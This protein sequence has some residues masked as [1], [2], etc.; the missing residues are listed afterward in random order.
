MCCDR[1]L[2]W[3]GGGGVLP[4]A[5]CAALVEKHAAVGFTKHQWV[6]RGTQRSQLQLYQSSL[7]FKQDYTIYL[8]SLSLFCICSSVTVYLAERGIRAGVWT[9]PEA[10]RDAKLKKKSI[11]LLPRKCKH[12]SGMCLIVH[13]RDPASLMHWY[14]VQIKSRRHCIWFSWLTSAQ[15]TRVTSVCLL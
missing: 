14:T 10:G 12:T 2:K 7:V 13:N 3:W 1:E 15:Q 8:F 5:K 6:M 9:R 4:G 11:T